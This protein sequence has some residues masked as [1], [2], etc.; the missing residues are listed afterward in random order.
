MNNPWIRLLI[1]TVVTAAVIV[2]V[3]GVL[4]RR[5]KRNAYSLAAYA[6][7]LANVPTSIEVR[8]VDE[9]PSWWA[10]GALS[11]ARRRAADR[12]DLA[13][14]AGVG[15]LL[16][17]PTW[18]HLADEWFAVR[19]RIEPAR[20]VGWSLGTRAHA[21]PADALAYDRFAGAIA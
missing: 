3:V 2:A 19:A 9:A 8:V 13:E 4:F 16:D 21:A 1:V 14:F 10:I 12:G 17:A 5:R 11:D 6:D 15:P 20:P 7:V 18:R